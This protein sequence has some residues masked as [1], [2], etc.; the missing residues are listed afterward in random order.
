[1]L[2]NIDP[3]L[4][5]ELLA[6]LRA[7]GHGDDIVVVDQNFPAESVAASTIH[8]TAIRLPGIDAP[9]VMAA[10]ASVLPID[11]VPEHPIRRMGVRDEPENVPEVQQQMYD[12]ITDG[13]G[14]EWPMGSVPWGPFDDEARKAYAVIQTGEGRAYGCMMLRKGV[15]FG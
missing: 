11:E 13:T 2:R 6:V 12:A 4:T 9:R 14:V 8:G 15:I 7:M 3:I 5:P 1:M 10:I